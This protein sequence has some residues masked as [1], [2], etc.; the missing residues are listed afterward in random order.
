M[1]KEQGGQHS[2]HMVG[3][4]ERKIVSGE[5]IDQRRTVLFPCGAYILE[6]LS[7]AAILRVDYIGRQ[8]I[9]RYQLL[10]MFHGEEC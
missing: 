4:G 9:N 10:G 1:L 3:E 5:H 6:G 8:R 2:W 7:L